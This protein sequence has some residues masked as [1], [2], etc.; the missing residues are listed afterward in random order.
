MH[1][2]NTPQIYRSAPAAPAL[3]ENS[4]NTGGGNGRGEIWATGVSEPLQLIPETPTGDTPYYCKELTGEW[5]LR[6]TNDI[7][8]NCR[9]GD[10][11]TA[12]KTGHSYWE[13]KAA[14]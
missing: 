2:S 5:T 13:R 9:P 12:T 14:A 8:N 6:T 7:M 11:R 4:A 3:F 10:W 1:Y